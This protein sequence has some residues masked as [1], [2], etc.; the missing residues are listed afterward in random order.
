MSLPK[1]RFRM[2]G[3][4]GTNQYVGVAKTARGTVAVRE[5]APGHYRIRVEPRMSRGATVIGRKLTR[6]F[7]WKQPGDSGQNRFSKVTSASELPAVLNEVVTALGVG[8]L[9]T[10]RFDYAKAL[11]HIGGTRVP[12]KHFSKAEILSRIVASA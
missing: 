3:T 4:E 10:T 5:V 9:K 11:R 7:G 2:A 6:E 8:S 12:A 1:S